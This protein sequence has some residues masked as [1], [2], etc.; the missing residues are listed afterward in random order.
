MVMSTFVWGLGR[1]VTSI[2][3][4]AYSRLKRLITAHEL[5]LF[6]SLTRDELSGRPMPRD[7]MSICWLCC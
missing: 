6:F 2:D 3:R 1:I 4:T 5:H 7:A